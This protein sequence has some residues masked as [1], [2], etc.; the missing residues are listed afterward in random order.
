MQL[1]INKTLGVMLAGVLLSLTACGEE[2]ES[3]VNGDNSA[4]GGVNIATHPS[5]QAYNGAGTG[6]ADVIK[7]N[8]DMQVS[9][10]PYSGPASW[11]SIFNEQ[12]EVNAGFLSLPDAVWA[13]NGESVF[14]E[15]ENVRALVKGNFNVAGGYT[16]E[17]D[18]GIDSLTDLEGRKV[19]ADYPGNNIISVIFEAQLNS[20]D[21]TFDDLDQ[22]PISDPN[23]GLQALREGRVEA[24]F[25]GSPEAAGTLELDSA[26][27]IKSLNFGDYTSSEID[28]IPEEEINELQSLIPGAEVIPYKGGFVPEET[29]LI[30]YPTAFIGH[31]EQLSEDDAY[32]IVKSL[33]E[34]YEELHPLHPWLDSW[35][36]ETMF[37]PD[38][39]VPYHPGAVEF[40]KEIGVW[41]EEAEENQEQLLNE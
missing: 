31:A 34:N 2:S 21:M 37:D 25:T 30:S 14:D 10:K 20:V 12:Q 40:Y 28:S 41:N 22:V 9:V 15:S 32:N 29:S 18:S 11:M 13:Y 7:D 24:T 33:W 3:T 1:K 23:T 4:S 16:V 27:S 19:A 8:S 39:E 5:G 17:E 36:Q 38:I 26:I 6:I 35:K